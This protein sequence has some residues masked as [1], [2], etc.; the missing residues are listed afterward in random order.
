MR[1]QWPEA[2]PPRWPP[3][4][5]VTHQ[6]RDYFRVWLCVSATKECVKKLINFSSIYVRVSL[7][8][9][10][11]SKLLEYLFVLKG[12]TQQKRM[13]QHPLLV[14]QVC[15][16]FSCMPFTIRS[17]TFYLPLLHCSCLFLNTLAYPCKMVNVFEYYCAVTK[18]EHLHPIF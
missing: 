3:Q 9:W 2:P 15:P 5:P 11:F 8:S 14:K 6:S 16:V 17:F 7:K 4:C 13:T 12:K 18:H 1:I 10:L